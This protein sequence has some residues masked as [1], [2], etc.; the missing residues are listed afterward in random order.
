MSRIKSFKAYD[1]RGVFGKDFTLEH[2]YRAGFHLP[3]LLA[4]DK[5]L[6]G[7]D[8][9]LSSPQIHKELCRGICDAGADVYDLGYATTPMVYYF[10]AKDGFDASVQITASHNPAH[11]NGMKVSS[12]NATP[13]GYDTGLG[14]LEEMILEKEVI[15]EKIKGKLINYDKENEYIA[16]LK[17][18]A[19]DFS[20]L[21]IAVDCSNGMAAL[22][23]HKILGNDP[24]YLHDTLDGS[25]PNHEPNPLEQENLQDLKR[26]VEKEG[27]DLG[28]IFDG[29]ADRV[30]FVDENAVFIPPDLIIALLGH[31]F[32]EEGGE[33]GMVIQ[34]IRSSKAIG[35]YLSTMGFEMHTWRVGRAFASPRLREIKGV[36]GGELAGH[37]YFRDFYYSDSGFLACLLVLRTL[38][39]FKQQGISFSQ[40][41]KKIGSYKNSGE[42][43]FKIE[44]KTEAMEAVKEFYF[45]IEEPLVFLDFDGYRLEYADF[46]LNIRPSNTEPYLRFI[47]EAKTEVV[48]EEII[49][50]VK[51]IITQFK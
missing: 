35:E 46:W 27:C 39:K 51:N 22:L 2:A 1:I 13:I 47:A 41:M 38:K 6:I 9:R 16:F 50:Q 49:T 40:I 26:M 23:V 24:I 29:D 4:A 31:Y 18:Y 32:K 37:Y 12:T 34:D 17:Q 11:Y 45:N 44:Q 30:M 5:V 3:A 19:D 36:Y 14:K 21:K 48:L 33:S 42:I 15:P 7:R 28:I 25:F 43:N 8:A 20:S 10:T